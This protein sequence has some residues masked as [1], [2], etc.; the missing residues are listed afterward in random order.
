MAA[1]FRIGGTV[2]G[3]YFTDRAA[4]VRRIA[5]VLVEPQAALLVYGSRRMGKTSA[6]EAA[7]ARVRR[8]GGAVVVADLSTGSTVSDVANR[9][10]LAASAELGRA[11][12]D[13][14]ADF[15]RRITPTL[16][17]TIDPVTGQPVLS[18][19]PGARAGALEDQR[20]TLGEVLNAIEAMAKARKKA[21]GIILDEFQEIHNFGG[22][23]AEWHL[24][25][26]MQKHKHI[27][28]VLAGSRESLI[29]EMVGKNRAF[30]KQLDMLHFGAIDPEHFARWID[31][32]LSG[33]GVKGTGMG[34]RAIELAGPRTRD[35]LQL[36]RATY[37]VA[38]ER[39]KGDVE[40]AFRQVIG[41]EAESIRAQW[42]QLTVLQQNVLRALAA[43]PAQLYSEAT[44]KRFGLGATGS[45]VGAVEALVT[46]GVVARTE[47]AV[48]FESPFT[49]GWTIMH[50]LPDAGIVMK[51][52]F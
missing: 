3:E 29:R 26:V 38:Q 48:I 39:G 41:E 24:R 32:R 16:A 2:S 23:D 44:R 9:I 45:V 46:K 34:G 40:A 11:W 37:Q 10:L 17:V 13:V 43:S 6:L 47:A 20:R 1:P 30:Y 42:D 52:P 15:A 18:L 14:A 50:A 22:E 12:K 5:A 25:G 7:A 33:A 27:G 49:R 28:Y 51:D 35:V 19:E 8:K 31:E 36:A 4:E 21:V